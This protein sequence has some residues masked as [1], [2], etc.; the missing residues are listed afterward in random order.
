MRLQLSTFI[1]RSRHQ[2]ATTGEGVE[3]RRQDHS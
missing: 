1:F 2:A 3:G